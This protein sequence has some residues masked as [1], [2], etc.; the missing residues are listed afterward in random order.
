M[1]LRSPLT[2]VI[3]WNTLHFQKHRFFAMS[4]VSMIFKQILAE[5]VE[6]TLPLA[7][8]RIAPDLNDHETDQ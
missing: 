5:T 1:I 6:S 4:S 7:V 3:F 8:L 2:Q